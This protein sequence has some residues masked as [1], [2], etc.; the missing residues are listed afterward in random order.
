MA[1]PE[2]GQQFEG[3]YLVNE[4]IG[5]GGFAEVYKATGPDGRPVA[6]KI[7][8]PLH[9]EWAQNDPIVERFEREG[10]LLGQ[11]RNEHTVTM[12]EMGRTADGVSP[13]IVFEFVDGADLAEVLE[14]QGP[15]PADRVIRILQQVCAALGEAHQLGVMHRDIKPANIMIYNHMGIQGLVK[16]LDFGI[17]KPTEGIS[18]QKDLTSAGMV[19]GTPRYMAPEQFTGA[20]AAPTSDIYSLGLVAYELVTGAMA[21]DAP[22]TTGIFRQQLSPEEFKIP[23]SAPIP[24]GLRTVIMKMTRKTRAERYQTVDEVLHDLMNLDRV[25]AP[26]VPRKVVK[27]RAMMAGAA[28]L[29][30]VAATGLAGLASTLMSAGADEGFAGRDPVAEVRPEGVPPVEPVEPEPEPEP[31]EPEPD[32]PE[33]V[34]KPAVKKTAQI[35]IKIPDGKPTKPPTRPT[36]TISIPSDSEGN[37]VPP[38][39]DDIEPMALE[40]AAA[41]KSIA[42]QALTMGD[43]EKVIAACKPWADELTFCARWLADAY[44]SRGNIDQACY[45]FQ[46]VGAEKT[47]LHCPY[48]EAL[49]E[50]KMNARLQ[51]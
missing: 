49:K 9:A 37:P 51:E 8:V 44:R 31:D 41:A 7:L 15:L 11:L 45:W 28:V 25:Q 35:G 33:L 43:W 3:K 34:D 46:V 24:S 32:E 1:L 18:A 20:R 29:A 16:L 23:R 27:S 4:H 40:S 19:L 22:T 38:P 14:T 10:R 36:T 6:I 39:E 30:L 2:P 17:A 13:Y 48:E 47:G 26:P 50:A 42:T 5:S 21:V 12:I